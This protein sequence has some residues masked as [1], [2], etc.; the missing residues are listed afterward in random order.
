VERLVV[1]EELERHIGARIRTPEEIHL[2]FHQLLFPP[3]HL[4]SLS[5]LTPEESIELCM[6]VLPLDLP[7]DRWRPN[8]EHNQNLRALIRGTRPPG[9]P[10]LLDYAPAIVTLTEAKTSPSPNA[11]VLARAVEEGCTLV[12][13][14]SRTALFEHDRAFLESGYLGQLYRHIAPRVLAAM[15]DGGDGAVEGNLEMAYSRLLALGT[16][17]EALRSREKRRM[18][19][20]SS[21]CRLFERLLGRTEPESMVDYLAFRSMVRARAR[22]MSV[23]VAPIRYEVPGGPA[24]DDSFEEGVRE[25]L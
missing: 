11:A 19:A 6:F 5:P 4:D 22:R 14:I 17:V 2:H 9:M 20:V 7:G 1:E 10:T 13:K 16:D 21:R 12:S 18:H 23:A 24:V 8:E 15:I 3:D 25:G